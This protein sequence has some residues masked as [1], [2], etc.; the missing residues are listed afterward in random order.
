MGKVPTKQVCGHESESPETR[1]N[2]VMQHKSVIPVLS[3]R[4]GKQTE[5][6]T[7]DGRL[8]TMAYGMTSS[9]TR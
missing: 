4:D 3:K 6:S 9:Q 8:S 1:D 5:E 2:R 7:E